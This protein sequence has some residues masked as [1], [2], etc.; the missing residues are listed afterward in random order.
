MVVRA[1][2]GRESMAD[3]EPLASQ[4]LDP[5]STAPTPWPEA[6]KLLAEADSYWLATVHPEG[7]PH[8][9][10]VLA[11]WVDGA[12]HIA[13]GP[14]TRKGN[15]L[16]LDQRCVITTSSAGF[17]LV[18]E[19]TAI[20]VKDEARLQRVAETYQVKYGWPVEV[21]NGA[22]YGE[23]AP[24]AGPPPYEVYQIA[25]TMAFAFG[26]DEGTQRRSTRWRF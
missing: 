7:R 2:V 26:T 24:T 8:V 19:G 4:T 14:A 17:D 3:R 16:A 1:P 20:K 25:L 13:T 6:R 12:V 10:P 22:F 18:V 9:R 11:V 15:N 21:R 5:G 23:G